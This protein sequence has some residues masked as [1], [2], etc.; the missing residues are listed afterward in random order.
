M[1]TRAAGKKKGHIAIRRRE[2]GTCHTAH[3]VKAT[4]TQEVNTIEG[5]GDAPQPF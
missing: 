5:D 4:P 2:E 3:L 1:G